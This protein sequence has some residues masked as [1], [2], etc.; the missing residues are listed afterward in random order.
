M[1]DI[2]TPYRFVLVFTLLILLIGLFS[3]V[4]IP[5]NKIIGY[6]TIFYNLDEMSGIPTYTS[7]Q[8]K[9]KKESC[10]ELCNHK[11]CNEFEIQ[12]KKYSL[13]KSCEKKGECYHPYQGT[14]VK[15]SKSS[16]CEAL[17]GSEGGAPMDPLYKECNMNWPKIY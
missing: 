3:I 9:Y 5:K 8:E 16:N 2:P 4:M 17:Y 1:K 12:N 15:C 10:R 11:V 6:R 13:C 14:C 7:N